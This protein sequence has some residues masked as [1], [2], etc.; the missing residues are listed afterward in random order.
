MNAKTSNITVIVP[1]L[2]SAA[3]ISITLESILAQ[4]PARI[5]LIDGNSEDDTLAVARQYLRPFDQIVSELDRGPYQAMN[6]G[7]RIADTEVVAILNSDDHWKPGTLALVERIFS[8]NRRVGIVHGN[9]D[10]VTKEGEH[11]LIIPTVGLWRYLGLGLPLV[12]PATFVRRQVYHKVG[13]YDF[14]SFPICAD[15]DF[16][17]R[18]LTRGCKD[19]HVDQVLTV[20]MAGGLS[21]G[22]WSHE[23]DRR[24]CKFGAFRRLMAEIVRLLLDRDDLYYN[25]MTNTGFLWAI[26]KKNRSFHRFT[27]L[28][29][30]ILKVLFTSL[31]W[32][33]R[34]SQG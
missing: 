12:H 33:I 28:W 21:S 14:D 5:L 19:I 26:V 20:M 32:P 17:H 30:P 4:T 15:I 1:T 6:K 27:V 23:L 10:Y 24:F 25:G 22:D 13:G 16:V 8:E 18:A 2:N 31:T 34:S 11:I 29:K 3:T 9:V 7:I